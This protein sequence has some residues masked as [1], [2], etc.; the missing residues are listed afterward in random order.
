MHA[1]IAFSALLLHIGASNATITRGAQGVNLWKLNQL[2]NS[3]SAGFVVQHGQTVSV[4]TPEDDYPEFP[5]QYFTQPLDHFSNETTDTFGQRYWVN[6]RHYKSGMGGPVI[7]LDGGEITGEVRL[8][9]LDTG[10]VDILAKATGGVGVV[11]EHRYYGKSVP[12]ANFS[13]DSLRWLNNDQSAADSANFMANVKF[14]GIDEDLT[15]PGTP[16]IYYGVLHH[17]SMPSRSSN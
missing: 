13:T 14:D 10:I 16:W 8:P 12:V 11:L 3:N 1:W 7:V 2:R 6:T 4:V 9:F 15:A 17:L 5:E